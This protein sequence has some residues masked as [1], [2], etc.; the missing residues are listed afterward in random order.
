MA[1]EP[2]NTELSLDSIKDLRLLQRK[3][4]YRYSV[5]SLLIAGYVRQSCKNINNVV[6]L[7]TGSGIIA[8][9]IASRFK[10]A[11]IQ[12]VELQNSLADL[13]E[14]NITLN[15]FEGRIK[16]IR[17]DVRELQTFIPDKS[18]E[19]VI[20]NPPYRR[21]GAGR[22]SP[23]EERALARHEINLNLGALAESAARILKPK[24]SFYIVHLPER[25]PDILESLRAALLE[26]KRMRLVQAR[27]DAEPAFVLLE[28]VKE[29]GTGLKI[30]PVFIMYDR[31]GKPTSEFASLYL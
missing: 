26:P 17:G 4:G 9:L 2:P 10:H 1:G 3:S 8:L 19:L 23:H 16:L 13:A 5:D 7:G 14:K 12:A 31:Q 24:G 25:L 29:G 30:D 6:D 22:I 15:S 27:Q 18:S 20:S 11:L 21:P 28:A